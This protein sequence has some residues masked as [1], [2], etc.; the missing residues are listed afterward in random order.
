[1]VYRIGLA[2]CVTLLAS[3]SLF[4]LPHSSGSSQTYCTI[5]FDSQGATT[6]SVP[7]S[8]SVVTGT[9]VTL[10]TPPVKT[11]N[12]FVGWYTQ[13]NGAGTAFADNTRVSQS[14]T[15]YAYW[16]VSGASWTATTLPSQE[17]WTSVVYGNNRF[18]A[19]AST[20]MRSAASTDGVTWTLGTLPST[21]YGWLSVAYGNGVFVTVAQDDSV[22]VNAI[23]TSTDGLNWTSHSLPSTGRWWNVAFAN[24]R[25]VVFTF[26]T[27]AA[28]YS[29]NG[30]QWTAATTAPGSLNSSVGFTWSTIS[31]GHGTFVIL[32]TQGQAS[33]TSS[34]GLTWTVTNPNTS[35]PAAGWNSLTYGNGTFVAVGDSGVSM[36]S[37]DGT[38]WT[39]I[40]DPYA[41]Y[42][43]N[44][45]TF[46]N[47]LFVRVAGYTDTTLAAT[48]PDGVTWTN[49]TLPTLNNW[50]AIA[51]GNQ[52][53]LTIAGG[54]YNTSTG[55]TSGAV[56]H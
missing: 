33:A 20:N 42:G 4:D 1:M 2:L 31:Y 30:T 50:N 16:T 18:V 15:L 35:I 29:D 5:T 37:P 48:S 34:D 41:S 10:P 27:G 49:R 23:A 25:F 53:F 9:A 3:C 7:A 56:S 54:P 39:A 38:N 36:T 24:G 45:I 47:G 14:L 6:P 21:G 22:N 19:V 52:T 17:R 32:A 46:G 26:D 12:Y 28:A 8:V 51:Y 43:W 40:P 11:G 44:S 55:S 13:P